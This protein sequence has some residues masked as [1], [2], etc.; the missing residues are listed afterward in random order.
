MVEHN[1]ANEKNLNVLPHTISF[2]GERKSKNVE[3]GVQFPDT[4][5]LLILPSW[6]NGTASA[7]KAE[8]FGYPGSIPGEGVSKPF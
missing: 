1:V 8:P 5:F 2:N 7:S 6:H 4:A 3:T